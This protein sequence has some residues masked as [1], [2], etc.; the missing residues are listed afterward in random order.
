MRW[1]VLGEMGEMGE[2]GSGSNSS[3]WVSVMGAGDPVAG[4]WR[5]RMRV[6]LTT[7][8]IVPQEKV[9]VRCRQY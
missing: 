2:A 3:G 1:V 9:R 4:G 5:C 8:L 6:G 7:D